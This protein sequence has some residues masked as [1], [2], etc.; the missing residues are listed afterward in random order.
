MNWLNK[1]V[2]VERG[3]VKQI[4]DDVK[5]NCSAKTMVCADELLEVLKQWRQ[6]TKFSAPDDWMF[7]S[8]VQLG[9]LPYG[10]SHVWRTLSVAA[11]RAGIEHVSSHVFRHTHRSWLDSVGTPVGVQQTLMR[12]ADICTTMN[13]YGDAMTADMRQAHEKIVHLALPQAN[14]SQTDHTAC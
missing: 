2:R 4:V 13:I 3:V 11:E 6:T 7:A 12:P 5:T 8:P 14:G 10:Y 1:T 9:R